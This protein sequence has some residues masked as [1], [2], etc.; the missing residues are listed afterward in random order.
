MFERLLRF[1]APDRI[2]A[3]DRL[4]DRMAA[5]VKRGDAGAL[6]TLR[7]EFLSGLFEGF[8]SQFVGWQFR[9]TLVLL[10]ESGS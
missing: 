6:R 7:A 9:P 4:L 2:K 1:R 8:Q 3:L 10:R 5:A